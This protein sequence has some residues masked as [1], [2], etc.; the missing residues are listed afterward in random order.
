LSDYK[1]IP[2]SVLNYIAKQIGAEPGDF[3]L[4]AQREPTCREHI[5]KIRQA[6]GYRNFTQQE[7]Q[8]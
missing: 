6:Y 4:Y 5:E 3:L 1:T 7:Y 8:S 2:E